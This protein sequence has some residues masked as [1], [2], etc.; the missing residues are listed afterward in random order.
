MDLG[1]ILPG[2]IP[3]SL[4]GDR[5]QYNLAVA[6]RALS[7]L[8]DQ[9]STG[10]RFFSPSEDPAAAT[11]AVALQKLLERKTQARTNV[12]DG[13]SFLTATDSALA[14]AGDALSSAKGLITSGLGSGNSPTEKEALANEAK[15][16]LQQMLV[17]ANTKFSGR[18]LFGGTASSTAPFV[19]QADGSVRYVGNQ[20]QS[21]I[22]ADLNSLV[23]VNVDGNTAFG[24]E[25][26]A[27]GSDINPALTL[28]TQIDDLFAGRGATLGQLQITLNNGGTPQTATIDLSGAQ[29]VNDIKQR[30]EDAFSGGPLTLSVSIDPTTKSGLRLASSAGTVQVSE[31]A[32]GLTAADLGI[33]G[34]PA[35][36][37]HGTDL[38]PRLT[39]QTLLSSLNGGA[40]IDQSGSQGL[41]ITNGT[42]T[43]TIDLSTATTVEDLFNALAT[44]QINV[45]GGIN[46]AGNG[47]DIRSQVSGVGFSIGENGGTTAADL[48]IRTLDGNTS[49]SDLNYGVGVPVN[50][51]TPLK[52]T[53]RDG[54]SVEVSLAGADT[55]QDVLNALNAADPGHLVA[56]L[57]SVGNG[58]QLTDDSGTG[59]LKIDANALATA[60]GIDG[61]ESGS[62]PATPLVGRDVNP[63]EAPGAFNVL[64]RLVTALQNGDDRELTR[65]NG[66][67]DREIDRVNLTRGDVGQR[68][69]TL[70]RI[71][72]RL[73]DETQQTKETLSSVFD[74][75]ITAA[76]TELASRQFTMEAA[77]RVAA[78]TMQLSLVSYL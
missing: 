48:G 50:D 5:L 76:V 39:N 13:Q 11:R 32:G 73:Q 17:V 68:Q 4:I 26:P 44:A 40:G 59:P 19:P 43:A 3:N 15:G 28:D 54:S 27:L 61:T 12:Q 57:A 24:A 1:P 49:L 6:T 70:D 22:L 34:G 31:V 71:D 14:S 47:L 18:Y 69:Q 41:T 66:L 8:Q 16:L 7:R 33:L 23:A 29:T 42:Q 38:D 30:L 75:D 67:I 25:S 74:T 46:A 56:S 36:V 64:V 10:H 52:I 37:I 60:L 65:L 77:L 2:R 9:I 78:Q 21:S 20:D 35:A 45:T 58:I 53:R 55:L 63:Q 62:N 51:G 72:S